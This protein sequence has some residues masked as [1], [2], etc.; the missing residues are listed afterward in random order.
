MADIHPFKALLYGS[1]FAGEVGR[2]IAPPYDI[3]DISLQRE[4]LESHPY[5]IVRLILPLDPSGPG[6]WQQQAADEYSRWKEHG[7]L[8]AHERN[9]LY[10]Y[11]Q[12]FTLPDGSSHD[13]HALIA[14]Y[15]IE[16]QGSG[17]V[18]PHEHT[19]PRVTEEQ[20]GLLR[21]CRAAFSQVFALFQDP[22][23][24]GKLLRERALQSSR[25]LFSF[26]YPS[27]IE[28]RLYA[29]EDPALIDELRAVYAGSKVFIA[30]GHHRYETAALYRKECR[31]G[32]REAAHEL[33]CDFISMAFVGI[34]DPGLILMPVHRV[35]S[36]S[37]M[38]QEEIL[39]RLG[40]CGELQELKNNGWQ[41]SARAA[42]SEVL[43][44]PSREP[45]FG[46]VTPGRVHLFRL[47]PGKCV[48]EGPG[49]PSAYAELDVTLLHEMILQ[50]CLGLMGSGEEAGHR[51]DYVVDVET[52]LGRIAAK[53][54]EV[55]FLQ[56]SPTLR[57][58]WE[59]A[60][61]GLKMPHKST[62]FY[63]KMPSGL[64]IYDHALSF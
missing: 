2:L 38:D 35:I 3:I 19:F 26:L 50:G 62:Y 45:I 14:L 30:D 12:S 5:N 37:G 20:L 56:R 47:D 29:L 52:A 8:S 16:D 21:S 53:Q 6:G 48:S 24:Y 43:S 39:S 61:Q 18:Y 40:S 25:K 46:V 49:R 17:E 22:P 36:D 55:A 51:I 44:N 10:I 54:A 27:S 32:I 13:R 57:Q 63:P 58:A 4:L 42:L 28:H 34:N 7:V 31:S 9:A 11:R 41:E 60:S 23:E 15:R 59:I 33:P 64:V 1:G